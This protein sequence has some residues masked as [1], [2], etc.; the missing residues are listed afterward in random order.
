MLTPITV[1]APHGTGKIT[2][3]RPDLDFPNT[4]PFYTYSR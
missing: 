4:L 3:E 2:G 1:K